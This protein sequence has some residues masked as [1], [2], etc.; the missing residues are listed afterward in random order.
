MEDHVRFVPACS[1]A[2]I[3]WWMAAADL[4]CLAT[5]SEGCCNAILEAQACGLPVVTTRVGGNAEFVRDREDGFLVPFWD[6]SAFASA[7][8]E[9]LDHPWDPSSIAARGQARTWSDTARD[10]I[11]EFRL[12]IASPSTSCDRL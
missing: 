5:R 9:A 6:G 3:P 11:E 4:F 1:H 2:E 7:I 8:L 12:A 10:V